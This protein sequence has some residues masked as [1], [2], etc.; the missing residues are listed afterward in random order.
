MNNTTIMVGYNDK[1]FSRKM[2]LMS[3]LQ[4][5]E[6]YSDTDRAN[7]QKKVAGLSDSD[8]DLT[9]V[10]AELPDREHLD[11]FSE[12]WAGLGGK[13]NAITHVWL[14]MPEKPLKQS[15]KADPAALKSLCRKIGDAYFQEYLLEI[16]AGNTGK[17]EKPA[18]FDT[19]ETGNANGTQWAPMK[20]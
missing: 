20:A 17:T 19:K 16:S 6:N 5:V 11:T 4:S 12:A 2:R 18:V 8:G 9:V 13:E 1:S 14:G 3:V 10:W 15:N 7:L